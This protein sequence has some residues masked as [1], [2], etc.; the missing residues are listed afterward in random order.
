MDELCHSFAAFL[1]KKFP[2][3][4]VRKIPIDAGFACPNRDGTLGRDGC[5]FC[6]PYAAG[7]VATAG[8]AVERQIEL[9]LRRSP[10]T[11]FIAYFQANCNTHAP[12]GELRRRYEAALGPPRTVGLAVATRPDALPAPVLELLQEMAGRTWLSVELGLQS[13]HEASLAWL[14]RRHGYAQFL[15]S[16]AELRRRAIDVVVHLI[17]GIPGETRADMRATIAAM[18]DLRPAGVKFHLLHVLRGAELQAR[19]ERGE[20]PLLRRE[21]YVDIMCDLLERLDPGIVVHRLAVDREAGLL[22]APGWARDKAAVL[23]ALAGEMRRRGAF[24]GRLAQVNAPG[25]A[26]DKRAPML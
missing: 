6:D 21:E 7:P 18:N 14:R 13:I 15:S 11:S 9:R 5:V 8:W 3:Q 22:V 23:R 26:V 10:G 16:F 17:V 24:Q 1:K 19:H 25:P 4:R 12:L 2:G 20:L